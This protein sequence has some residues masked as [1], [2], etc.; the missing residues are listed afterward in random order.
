MNQQMLSIGSPTRKS[1]A[2]DMTVERSIAGVGHHMLLQS[3][4]LRERL[5][6]LLAHKALSALVLQQDVLVQILLCNHTPLADL[7]FVLGFKMRPLLV[8][9]QRIAVGAGFAANVAYY[10]GLLVLETHVQS[11][12]ALHFELLAAVLAVILVLGSVFAIEMLLQPPSARTFESADVARVLRFDAAELA[13]PFAFRGMFLA[14]VRVE[15]RL[16]G[17]LVAAEVATVRN[18]LCAL[19]ILFVHRVPMTL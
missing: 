11:H 12:V 8:H 2:A 18:I 7:A 1:F 17:A 9:V 3:V 14:D 13:L 19:C 15:S 6:A 5:A 10:R 4:I 16:V